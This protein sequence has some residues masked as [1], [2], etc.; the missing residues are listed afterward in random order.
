MIGI[1]ELTQKITDDSR[2]DKTNLESEIVRTTKLFGEYLRMHF[3]YKKY[4]INSESLLN[5]VVLERQMF[6]NGQ[7]EP[8]QYRDEP[9]DLVI[10]NGAEMERFLDGD[11]KICQ[12]RENADIAKAA[13]E[14]IKE[15]LDMLKFRNNHISTIL[16]VRKF[17]QGE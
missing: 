10:R 16:S 11:A 2:L 4:Y 7:A 1:T 17:E 6:Y 5:T 13:I 8:K 14:M 15:M 12:Q 9:F 3:D